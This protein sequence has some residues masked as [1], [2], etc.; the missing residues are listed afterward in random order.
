MHTWT[1]TWTCSHSHTYIHK[2]THA[3]KI[4]CLKGP[5]V[6][7]AQKGRSVGTSPR[8]WP[9][10]M[11]VMPWH[12]S[13]HF[14]KTLSMQLV[15][16]LHRPQEQRQEYGWISLR[17]QSVAVK[18]KGARMGENTQDCITVTSGSRVQDS[19]RLAS[20]NDG[21]KL[22]KVSMIQVVFA[23]LLDKAISWLVLTRRSGREEPTCVWYGT[24]MVVSSHLPSRIKP[25]LEWAGL[26]LLWG[27]PDFL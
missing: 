16:S 27:N 6:S 22:P 13:W 24:S 18:E 21:W 1:L 26:W 12:T 17:E 2:H 11:S 8:G 5:D 3:H 20:R 25:L 9:E 10:G 7:P 4:L 15:R 19:W 23:E 14:R